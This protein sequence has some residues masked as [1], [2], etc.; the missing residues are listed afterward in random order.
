MQ[1]STHTPV[2]PYL[3]I[4]PDDAFVDLD[5][6]DTI[7]DVTDEAQRRVRPAPLLPDEEPFSI[8]PA[9]QR[10]VAPPRKTSKL[11]VA[12]AVGG[13][14]FLGGGVVA[15]LGLVVLLGLGTLGVLGGASWW[16]L[17]A[18]PAAVEAPV[19]APMEEDLAPVEDAAPA[20]ED[21]APEA[22]EDAAEVP[23]PEADPVSDAPPAAPAQPS[24]APVAPPVVQPAA[25]A[26]APDEIPEDDILVKLLSD[27]PAAS[28]TIDGQPMGRTPLK[29]FLPAGSHT[30]VIE[31]GKASGQFTIDPSSSDRVCFKAKGRKVQQ[32]SCN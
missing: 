1:P 27:P 2:D 7:V 5:V 30:V 4:V 28:V 12:G 32:D 23:A 14:M 3:T 29:A 24:P 26:V 17:S 16:W 10:E 6:L 15:A 19:A 21:E 9:A 22:G 8:A 31:S 11:V 18:A 13:G 20:G 25:P